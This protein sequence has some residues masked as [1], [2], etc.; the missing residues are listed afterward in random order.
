MPTQSVPSYLAAGHCHVDVH[1]NG[2]TATTAPSLAAFGATTLLGAFLV[3]QVQPVISKCV[4][5]WFGGTPAV[6]TTCMLFFQVLLFGGYLYAHVLRTYFRP[7]V[8]ALIHLILLATAATLLPIEP[9]STWRP[10]GEESPML[11]LL[12]MLLVHVGMPYFVLSSTGPL[13]QAWLSYHDDSDRVYRLYALSNIGSLAALLSYPFIIE[14]VL[15]VSQQSSVWSALFCVFAIAQ[16]F[17]AIGLFR[18]Q[19]R[20]NVLVETKTSNETAWQDRLL[21]LSLPALASTMLLVVTNHVCQDVAV[22]PFLW[23]LPLSLYLVSFIVCFDSPQ[24][25]HPKAIAA[26]TLLAIGAIQAKG[27][28]PGSFQLIV[29]ASCYMLMLFGVCLLCH[30]EVARLKP[31]ARQLTQFYALISAGGAVGGLIVAVLCPLLLSNFAEVPFFVALV[32]SLSFVLFFSCRR[33]SGCDYD[34]AKAK[35]LRLPATVLMVAPLLAIVLADSDETLASKR[36]FF[37]VVRVIRDSQGIRLVHGS[38]I[39]GM[40]RAGTAAQE[41]TAYYG[42]SSGVGLTIAAMQQ[43]RESIRIGV[44]GLGC[45]VLAVYGRESDTMDMIEINP[46]VVEFANEYFTFL[47]DS[48]ATI[49]TRLGDGRLVLERM[50]DARFDVLVLDA[51]SSDAIPA[52]LMTCES[53]Q[54]Y[55]QRL[56]DGGVLA[57]HVSNNH[58]DLVPLAHRLAAQTGLTSRVMRVSGDETLGTKHSTWMLIADPDNSLWAHATLVTAENASA[59]DLKNG[60]LWTD[61]H[62][63]LVSVLRL[64]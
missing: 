35:R 60:P 19:E 11:H 7:A 28:L 53:M 31:A 56:T 36:N 38:T 5:P 55:C 29:E 43:Q 16:G 15:S 42:R 9:S 13:I 51:F 61:Q 6:W 23:V 47:S 26:I 1:P 46:A 8:Q 44:V 63:N 52:H 57:I 30:G 32:T 14:P 54:L 37:G 41:P 62:H 39:H 22:I 48:A 64:W 40:Q 34:W 45:G 20:T 59:A 50:R 33:W 2:K 24:W 12:W 49:Q 3:F 27:I 17:V 58:L 10:T 4:L 21:W 25:Y 18:V